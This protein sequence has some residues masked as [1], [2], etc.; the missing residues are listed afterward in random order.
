MKAIT[1]EAH[2]PLGLHG[3]L[4]LPRLTRAK[5]VEVE[6]GSALIIPYVFVDLN[7]LQLHEVSQ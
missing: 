4:L 1:P 6:Y 2:R 3:L 7:Y 5:N